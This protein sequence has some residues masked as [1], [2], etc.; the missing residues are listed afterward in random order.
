MGMRSSALLALAAFALVLAPVRAARLPV[1]AWSVAD[2]LAGDYINFIMVDSQG[3]VWICTSEGLSRF[4]GDEFLTVGAEPADGSRPAGALRGSGVYSIAEDPAGDFWIASDSG[5]FRY[6]TSRPRGDSNAL[7]PVLIAGLEAEDWPT[8]VLADSRGRIWVGT[9]RM[10][11]RFDFAEGAWHDRRLAAYEEAIGRVTVSTTVLLESGNGVLAGTKGQGIVQVS[12]TG[13]GELSARRF[14]L[15]DWPVGST[16]IRDLL[17]APDGSIWASTLS[18]LARFRLPRDPAATEVALGQVFTDANG[19]PTASCG[20]LASRAADALLVATEGGLAEL[21]LKAGSADWSVSRTLTV[22]DGLSTNAV[23]SPVLDAFGN[24]WL[25][26]LTNGV[27]R[28]SSVGATRFDEATTPG[29]RLV[30][31]IED[32]AGHICALSWVGDSRM[33]LSC[34]G[35]EG[36]RSIEIRLPKDMHYPGWGASRKI[37]HARDGSWWLATGVGLFRWR[38]G[39]FEDLGRRLPDDRYTEDS[40][41]PSRNIF[42]L[43]EDSRGGIWVLAALGHPLLSGVALFSPAQQRFVPFTR[44]ELPPDDL[45]ASAAEDDAGN[46][47]IGFY[48]G[49]VARYANGRFDMFDER[50]G[51]TLDSVLDLFVDSNG[52]LWAGGRG[53]MVC[54]TPGASDAAS[55]VFHPEAAISDFSGAGFGCFTEDDSGR[56]YFGTGRGLFRLNLE[57]GELRRFTIRDGLPGNS[58]TLCQRAS[59]GGLWMS[60]HVGLSRLEPAVEAAIPPPDIRIVRI[61]AGG[62]AVPVPPLGGRL[63]ERVDLRSDHSPVVIECTSVG[64]PAGEMMRYQIKLV[65]ADEDWGPFMTERRVQYAHLAPGDYRFLVRAVSDAGVTSEPPAEVK[66]FVPAPLW[67]RGWFVALAGLAAGSAGWTLLRARER[68]LVELERVRTRI[69]TDLHDDI[70]SSLSQISILSQVARQQAST[71]TGGTGDSR[72]AL[73][74]ITE[75]SGE[76]VDSIGDVVWSINPERDRLPDLAHRMRRFATDLFS[77]ETG[78]TLSI[79]LPEAADGDPIDADLRR[80]I[81]RLFKEALHNILKHARARR[82]EVTFERLHDGYRLRIADDGE[83]FDVEGAERGHGLA[84]MRARADSIGADLRIRSIPSGGGGTEII[85]TTGLA[86]RRRKLSPETVAGDGPKA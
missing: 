40:G 73:D 34:G 60:E 30:D 4:D 26:G 35:R 54:D 71:G 32:R 10:L 50:S 86:L 56:L 18:C 75:L 14:T 59:D 20:G 62:E 21:R 52:R 29:G 5:L 27:M 46:V 15:A 8:E 47:W 9:R 12:E 67:R 7:V 25:G 31:V 70:G 83:G 51:M 44:A 68:R 81:Y 58:I 79:S 57:T 49:K 53:A 39:S 16:W 24:I 76:L 2:G 85:L 37:L 42:G 6:E 63:L 72:A 38:K 43:F 84:S 69:A 28:I 13:G 61:S 1:T 11:H 48:S 80:Q 23:S 74:R 3:F 66:L 55:I 82:V 78:V 77:P 17:A 36:F 33:T 65:G 22:H 64:R 41:L 19:L 45:A